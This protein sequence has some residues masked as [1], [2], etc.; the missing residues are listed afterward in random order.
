MNI[1]ILDDYQNAL[2]SL[3]C[4]GKLAGHAVTVWNDHVEDPDV[5]AA[6]LAQTEVLI[7]IRERMPVS[8]ALLERLP[9]LR[10]ISQY[11]ATPHI[12]LAAC[13]RRGVL[14]CS[15]QFSRPSHATAEFTWGLVIAALRR[16]PQEA[17]RLKAGGWQSSMGLGLHGRT[18]GIYGFGRI[19]AVV[20]GYGRAFGM[21]VL[22][23]GRDTTLARARNEGYQ[24]AESRQEF[25][26]Q[27]D[28]LSLHMRLTGA[29]RGIVSA[30]DLALM[31]PT[32]LLVNTSRAGLIAPGVLAHALRAGRPG[33]AAVDVF[34]DE[35]VHNACDPL[36]ALDNALCTPHLGYVE[37]DAYEFGFGHVF[38]QVAAYAA[39]APVNVVN[40]DVL[41]L[42]P[43]A[44]PA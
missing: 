9:A 16:I 27:S 35:P 24:P 4:F 30:S 25:F 13:T 43:H 8:A 10:L 6:R 3:A 1:S 21:R 32:A 18:L 12:D 31:K 23:W 44:R 14:V 40:A 26:E 22:A 2:P 5:L 29:T 34:E 28:V 41:N 11:G 42:L 17:V 36:L 15:A 19:G 7:L 33:L 37:R 38:E 39:G 20:A